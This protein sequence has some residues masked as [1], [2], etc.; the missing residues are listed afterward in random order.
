MIGNT[1]PFD[2]SV[3]QIRP[4][5]ERIPR[6]PRWQGPVSVRTTTA[7]ANGTALSAWRVKS[8]APLCTR[9]PNWFWSPPRVPGLVGRTV[10]SPVPLHSWPMRTDG[11]RSELR[12]VDGFFAPELNRRPF[13]PVTEPS[14]GTNQLV[15]A[16]KP[17]ARWLLPTPQH[18]ENH[19]Y[20]GPP[21][22]STLATEFS[23]WI[24]TRLLYVRNFQTWKKRVS[25]PRNFFHRRSTISTTRQLSGIRSTGI[26]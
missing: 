19:P 2:D 14:V 15:A 20:R 1:E 5:N 12:L 8:T 23:H 3:R 4:R 21:A 25:S 18:S 17:A 24:H 9:S 11:L 6:V 26:Q 16:L 7:R 22:P 10:G 13:L